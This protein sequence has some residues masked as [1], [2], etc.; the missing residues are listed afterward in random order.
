M[1]EKNLGFEGWKG[2]HFVGHEIAH[3]IMD[4]NLDIFD[5]IARTMIKKGSEILIPFGCKL[6]YL[7][8]SC[9]GYRKKWAVKSY[10]HD[11]GDFKKLIDSLEV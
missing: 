10:S 6:I 8:S 4:N 5:P 9:K 2:F 3:K 11:D 1:S 7:P